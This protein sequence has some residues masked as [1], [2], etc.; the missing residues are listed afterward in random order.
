MSKAIE[1]GFTVRRWVL[2]IPV[3]MDGPATRWWDRWR[4]RQEKEHGVQMELWDETELISLLISP[5]TA[6]V[7][8]HYYGVDRISP[9]TEDLRPIRRLKD[10]QQYDNA[11]FIRQMR[12][13]GHTELRSC[14]EQFFNAEI[15][16]REIHDKGILEEEQSFVTADANAHAIWEARFSE[17]CERNANRLLPGLH[18]CVMADVR[19]ERPALPRVLRLGPVHAMGLVHRTVEDGRAG[20]VRDFRRIATQ[21]LAGTDDQVPVTVSAPAQ[22]PGT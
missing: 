19:A 2:C 18:Q 21:H 1:K 7:R 9:L 14:K 4:K 6:Y 13:A 16:A 15:I 20:W 10:P 3:S 8:E 5:D 17:A 12:E 22:E 11:L